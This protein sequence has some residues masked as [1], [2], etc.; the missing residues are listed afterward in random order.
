MVGGYP[1]YYQ[2]S[3][4]DVCELTEKTCRMLRGGLRMSSTSG[5]D[6]LEWLT[7]LVARS[8]LGKRVSVERPRGKE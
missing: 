2:G 7:W 6:Q 8:K 5:A 4:E 3:D 1:G